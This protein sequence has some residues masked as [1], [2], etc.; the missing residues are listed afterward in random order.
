MNNKIIFAVL[1]CF[2]LAACQTYRPAAVASF[3]NCEVLDVEDCTNKP[4]S[5][6]VTLTKTP[7]GYNVNPKS[8]C[9]K[10]GETITFNLVPPPQN[11]LGTAAIIPKVN[12]DTWLAGINSTHKHKI[13]ITVPEWVSEDK[14]EYY[15]VTST[16]ICID[17]RVEVTY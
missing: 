3:A 2:A 13:E 4:T 1:L 14:Y 17:P 7:M 9:V 15:F 8:V 12:S 5:P 10:T 11:L 16:G 6:V